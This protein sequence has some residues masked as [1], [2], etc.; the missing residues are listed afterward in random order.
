MLLPSVGV[1]STC[2]KPTSVATGL[3]VGT[4]AAD[5][6]WA[7]YAWT[8][9]GVAG[10]AIAGL[11]PAAMPAIG[12]RGDTCC[13]TQPSKVGRSGA[14][15]GEAGKDALSAAGILSKTVNRV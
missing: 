12:R 15:P 8:V 13:R 6:C 2:S 3:I 4:T 5:W 1:Q 10:L 14:M 7:T 9:R 11:T